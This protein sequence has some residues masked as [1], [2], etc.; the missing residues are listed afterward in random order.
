V[1]YQV[2]PTRL[3]PRRGRRTVAVTA[4]IAMGI[5][6]LVGGLALAGRAPSGNGPVP[7]MAVASSAEPLAFAATTAPDVAPWDT[8]T[9]TI[10]PGPPPRLTCHGVPGARCAD[11]LRAVLIAIA[12][13]PIPHPTRVDIWA[14]LLCGDSFDCP[15][16]Q[17]DDRQPAGSAVVTAG[18][19]WLWVN[20]TDALGASGPRTLSAWVIRSGHTS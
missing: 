19:I 11:I 17:I 12:D 15:P 9:P 5:A 2:D 8:P 3:T 7:P 1:E 14:S 13:P 4:A 6:V 10:A 18:S 16:G 20:V